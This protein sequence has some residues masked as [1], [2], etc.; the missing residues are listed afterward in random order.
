MF[1]PHLSYIAAISV[2][3]RTSGY[4]WRGGSVRSDFQWRLLYP[5]T[6]GGLREVENALSGHPNSWIC[7]LGWYK[8]G[9]KCKYPNSPISVF[10]TTLVCRELTR[11]Q[12]GYSK[13]WLRWAIQL[14]SIEIFVNFSAQG[15]S[16]LK[17]SV[18]IINRRSWG[19]QNTPNLQ[20]LDD[21]EP[22]YGTLKKNKFPKILVLFNKF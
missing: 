10:W 20:S 2:N 15:A 5:K 13:Y 7:S 16:I 1:R 11:F 9:V 3:R 12:S 18:P 4:P 14:A 8:W 17:I 21:F 22:S 6:Y 19:F